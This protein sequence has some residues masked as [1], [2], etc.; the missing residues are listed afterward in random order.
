MLC[1]AMELH[2]NVGFFPGG[3]FTYDGAW[4]PFGWL[5]VTDAGRARRSVQRRS[6]AVI[7]LAC[8]GLS[9]WPARA[10]Q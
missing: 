7:R 5:E 4:K 2:K 6:V 9:E 3:T 1:Y 10:Q 8:E